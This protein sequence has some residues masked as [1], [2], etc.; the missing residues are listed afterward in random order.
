MRSVIKAGSP[1]TTERSSAEEQRQLVRRWARL[2]AFAVLLCTKNSFP[3]RRPPAQSFAVMSRTIWWRKL[4]GNALNWCLWT[5]TCQR[6]ISCQHKVL[7]KHWSFLATPAQFVLTMR[8]L[9]SFASLWLCPLPENENLIEGSL[10]WPTGVDP[11]L[12]TEVQEGINEWS[13]NKPP[14]FFFFLWAHSW[15]FLDYSWT[16]M[17]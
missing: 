2:E 4:W 7:W 3:T 10:L 8:L 12:V 16:F 14:H 15:N 13:K 5:S 9:A 11:A 6:A 1:D 17:S